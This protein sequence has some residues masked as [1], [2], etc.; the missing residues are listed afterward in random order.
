MLRG[1]G[2][3]DGHHLRRDRR[4]PASSALGRGCALGATHCPRAEVGGVKG[5]SWTRG[6]NPQGGLAMSDTSYQLRPAISSTS[7]RRCKVSLAMIVR[8][9][10]AN[11]TRCLESA[12]GLFDEI[13][14]VDT[15]SSDRTAAIA[16]SF[17]AEVFDLAWCD[18]FAAARNAALGHATGDY[19]FRLDADE[20]LYAD[21]RE[22]S[23]AARST[24]CVPARTSSSRRDSTAR[25]SP[26]QGSTRTGS[27][28][29]DRT[30]GGPAGSTRLSGRRSGWR[31]CRPAGPASRFIRWGTATRTST[32]GSEGATSESSG[33]S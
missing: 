28:R 21:E 19:V 29:D 3:A 16:R 5:N 25:G 10:E 4:R 9:E 22:R 15:G 26:S 33:P 18:D 7:V 12:R 32:P 1:W 31:S 24:P 2:R 6:R 20:T 11:L 23:V 27:S 17:G 8:D 30:S 14:V 13:I